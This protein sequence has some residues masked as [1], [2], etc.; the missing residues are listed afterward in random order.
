MLIK[1]SPARVWAGLVIFALQSVWLSPLVF[2]ADLTL[3]YDQPAQNWEREA[4][5]IGNGRIGAMLFGGLASDRVQFNDIS[6][7]TGSQTLMGAYQAFGNLTISLPGHDQGATDYSRQLDLEHAMGRV[8]Y[9]KD[10]IG[11]TREYFASHPAQVIV[12]RLTADKSGAY[13][14][15]IN[16]ADMHKAPT[17]AAG[18][19]LIASG[20]LTV[21]M[22]ALPQRGRAA[23]AAP[24]KAP[25]NTATMLYESQ[26]MV[27]N[28]GGSL[29][30]DGKTISFTGCNSITILLGAG[31]DYVMDYAKNFR[32]EPPHDKLTAQMKEA[33]SK[34]F[35]TLMNEHEADFQSLFGRLTLDLGQASASQIALPTDKRIAAYTK[36]GNDPGLEAMFFQ[37]G[38]YL[39][40][41]CS[42]DSLPS[43]LQGLWNDRNN[44][45]WNSDYHTNI[46]IQMCYW[47]A[48]P[49]NLSECTAP[50][51]N[52]VTAL[53]PVLRQTTVG[54]ARDAKY[55]TAAGAPVRGWTVRTSHNIFGN[56]SYKWNTT[57]N[58]WYAQHFWEHYAFTGDK[59]YLQKTAYPV[60]KEVCQFW[61]D[62]LKVLP[63]GRLVAPLG[64]SP[65]HGPTEDG[66]TYDQEI[67]WDLFN[68]TIA[69][70]DALGNDKEYRDKIAAM[71]DKL[72]KPKIG[73][74]GQL[75]EWMEDIDDPAD[76]HRHVSQLFGLF[77]GRQFSRTFT[78]ELAQAAQVSLEHR[79][80]AGTGWSMAWK[81]A[82]WAR[83]GDGNHAHKMLRGQLAV[84]GSRAAEQST[85][86]TETNNAGGT[87]S[88]LLDAH[89]PFQIDGNFG[90]TAAICE[91]LLQSQTG[92]IQLL[93]A[94]P[95]DWP[96]GS[97]KG[98]R[99]RGGFAVDINWKNGKLTSANIHSDKGNAFQVR[100]GS[101]V[102]LFDLPAGKSILIKNSLN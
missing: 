51:F 43:N 28:E 46:N 31:T 32:G 7:W 47:P 10:G 70:A 94:L 3:H 8:T 91:M 86:G 66:V 1:R 73:K 49:A 83:L 97:V 89:P 69:A 62:Y 58:A 95:S 76:T 72:V 37:Y 25:D 20:A 65:E 87:F 44:P 2:T 61:E 14:G 93:P 92:E 34:S 22:G 13:T 77:P 9:N 18:N 26:A 98:L 63:D 78:P 100:Y 48:E 24:T 96:T 29:S 38:R 99:A 90:A 75:Q 102:Q 17:V 56:E 16:L 40:I 39:L 35:Q 55:V 53:L 101:K 71:R 6:L 11:Y 30:T 79:G 84:P 59:D 67:I 85:R 57:G 15:S 64:W 21:Q 41:S 54:P 60:M 50:L 81:I 4:L 68:N 88:N 42:R 27:I 80:D 82:Y 52:M 36:D 12:V 23:A 33:S 5:P 45:P 74:W 19:T